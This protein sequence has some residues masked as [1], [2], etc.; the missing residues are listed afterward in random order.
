M[1][2]S[3]KTRVSP[4]RA[5]SSCPVKRWPQGTKVFMA[6]NSWSKDRKRLLACR[7]PR[8]DSREAAVQN[9]FLATGGERMKITRI[10]T[11]TLRTGGSKDL[12]FCRVETENG[13]YGWGDVYITQG[14]E[15]VVAECIQAMAP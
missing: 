15:K 10:E 1:P 9:S 4:A 11:F 5:S 12:L 13:L 7:L 8:L 6:L 14:K 2:R 3:S